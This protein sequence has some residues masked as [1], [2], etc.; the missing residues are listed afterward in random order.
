MMTRLTTFWARWLWGHTR[1]EDQFV[2][3]LI[4]DQRDSALVARVGFIGGPNAVVV[5]VTDE[6]VACRALPLR[7]GDDSS[8]VHEGHEQ[9]NRSQRLD[10]RTTMITE[11]GGSRSYLA[12]IF[13]LRAL[14]AA[15]AR[16]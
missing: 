12:V 13:F 16:S 7:H 5:L 4:D 2:G 14:N 15:R 3:G 9:S 8:I 1:R 11:E 10:G 6:G